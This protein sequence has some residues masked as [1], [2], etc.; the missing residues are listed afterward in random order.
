MLPGRLALTY[1]RWISLVVILLGAISLT[2]LPVDLM[3]ESEFPSIT[4]RVNYTGV[5]PLEME[6]LVTRPIEQAVSAIAG[7]E[8]V[9]S[10]SS[11]GNANV[12]L[13]FA[14]GTDLNEAADEVRT[15]V[16]R[17]RGR[18]PEDADP[19]TVFKF[20]ST[21][22]PIMNVGVEGDYDRV[23]LR[24]I[25]EHDL[26]QRL[27]RVPGVAAVTVQGG[28]RRQ[29][30]VELSKEKIRALDLP[31]D[32]VVNLLRTENQNIPLGEIDEGDRTYLVRS[33]GQFSNLNE[34]RDMVVMTRQ[35]VP[36]YMRD[37]AVVKDSTEDFR[38][39]TRIN[40]KP[41][42]RLRITKQSG[43]N[44]VAIADAVRTEVAK[45]NREMP[46]VSL[47]VLD[48]SS[49]FINRSIHAVQEHAMVGG[50]LVMA[51][52]FVFLRNLRATIIPGLAIPASIIAAF[53]VMY[54]FGFSINNLTLLALT[55]AIGIVVDD[56]IIVL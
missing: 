31:V 38:S 9:N 32:R 52:I 29:I 47:T 36:V 28:L 39:F 16:D 40:G 42:V 15:R 25:A 44:T 35:G 2:R 34:I 1:A 17:V 20:D 6:E 3:P 50:F 33:Q 48:D 26:S 19:P 49:I 18:M 56:A 37:I 12:R 45:I 21:S 51:I 41:G 53:A 4:V 24:E 43:T 30:H 14:W 22:M 7:L 10:T 54:F 23:K 55:L 27:E 11:E 8:Q 5:G 13:Q 46:S